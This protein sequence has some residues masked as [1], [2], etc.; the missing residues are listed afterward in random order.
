MAEPIPEHSGIREQKRT[1]PE[2]TGIPESFHSVG[3]VEA[4]MNTNERSIGLARCGITDRVVVRAIAWRKLFHC[5]TCRECTRTCRWVLYLTHSV[6]P[7]VPSE[8]RTSLSHPTAE[9]G[10][11][12]SCRLHAGDM[13]CFYAVVGDPSKHQET[14]LHQAVGG[15]VP[16]NTSLVESAN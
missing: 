1:A 13:A 2:A 6:G 9:V 15:Y 14:P 12:H 4:Q 5:Y 8:S 3:Y 11:T 10:G 16:V 7:A